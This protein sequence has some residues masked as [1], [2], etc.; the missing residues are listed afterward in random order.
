LWA[1]IVLVS[2]GT[3]LVLM[4]KEEAEA[5]KGPAAKPPVETPNPEPAKS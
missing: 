5:S 3:F 4:S 2:L 1:G